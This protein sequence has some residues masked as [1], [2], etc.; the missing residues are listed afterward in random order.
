ML[1]PSFVSRWR[2]NRGNR[3]A[4][5]YLFEQDVDDNLY[6]V[7]AGLLT[8]EAALPAGILSDD[9][10]P[11]KVTKLRLRKEDLAVWI[12]NVKGATTAVQVNF[13]ASFVLCSPLS[14]V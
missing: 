2:R 14:R 8:V 1:F 6:H 3:D 13:L 10:I 4:P 5:I 9:Q 7:K 11:D 12:A